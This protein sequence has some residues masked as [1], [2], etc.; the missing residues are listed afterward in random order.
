MVHLQCA[1][2]AQARLLE[3]PPT[4]ADK[5]RDGTN[6]AREGARGRDDDMA[7]SEV[8]LGSCA[9]CSLSQHAAAGR[10]LVASGALHAL[11]ALL[12]QH[13]ATGNWVCDA[14]LY[15][16]WRFVAANAADAAD[17]RVRLLL[18]ASVVEPAAMAVQAVRR[19]AATIQTLLN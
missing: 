3:G 9:A 16:L 4:N 11:V 7:A 12:N 14:I 15:F 10:A 18:D 8:A 19:L 13:L 2:A 5:A 1:C 6:T 17:N